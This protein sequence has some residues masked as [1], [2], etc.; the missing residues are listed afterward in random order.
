VPFTLQ[1]DAF[2]GR[3]TL[4]GAWSFVLLNRVIVWWHRFMDLHRRYRGGCM[5]PLKHMRIY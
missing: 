5:H 1:V 3:L 2:R 4:R